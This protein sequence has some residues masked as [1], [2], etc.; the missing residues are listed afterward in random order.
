MARKSKIPRRKRF[1]I[2][3]EGE[4]EQGYARLLQTFSDEMGLAVHI[5]AKVMLKSGDPLKKAERAIA[6]LEQEARGSK[7]AF[8]GRFLQFDTDVI[9]QN[10][11]RDQEMN[12]L[13]SKKRIILIRQDICFESF[14]LRHF[15]GHEADQPATSEEALARLRGIWPEYRK[16]ASAQELAQYIKL[17][18]A[19]RAASNPLNSDFEILFRALGVFF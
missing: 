3:C 2:G 12:N 9:G 4:S 6:V 14:L 8:V 10:P 11:A 13:T 19:R 18:H 1:F 7:P 15:E 16:G 17:E 5:V